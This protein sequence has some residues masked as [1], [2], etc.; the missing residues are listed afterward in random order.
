M[1]SALQS[2]IVH[3]V[4]CRKA[5]GTLQIVLCSICFR[6]KKSNWLGFAS[7]FL[8]FQR[9]PLKVQTMNREGPQSN[10]LAGEKQQPAG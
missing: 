4:S 8:F 9:V 2:M 7:G 6:S 1:S 10:S 5:G 3:V